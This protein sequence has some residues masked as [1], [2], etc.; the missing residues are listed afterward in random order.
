MRKRRDVALRN[1]RLMLVLSIALPVAR[2]GYASW[3]NYG[4]AF[5][6]ADERN[7]RALDIAA[8]QALRVF[9]SV[10]VIFDSVEQITRGATFRC[11]PRQTNAM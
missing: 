9:Q 3:Q 10:N 5:Q 1:L 7:E 4:A 8:E 2:F 11:R 6:I